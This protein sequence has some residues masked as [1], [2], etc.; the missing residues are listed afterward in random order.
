MKESDYVGSQAGT[1]ST[2][3]D[4]QLST[5]ELAVYKWN[6]IKFR[7]GTNV[8]NCMQL[9]I[10]RQMPSVGKVPP[11]IRRRG[12]QNKVVTLLHWN[13]KKLV[14]HASP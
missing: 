11:V 7:T 5:R 2:L 4:T 12:G 13:L 10:T 6:A 14:P 8:K 1:S 3:V 9:G